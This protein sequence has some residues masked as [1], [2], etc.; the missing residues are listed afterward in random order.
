MPQGEDLR[1]TREAIRRMKRIV[2]LEGLICLA[3]EGVIASS[4][5]L[6]AAHPGAF[7][8]L[9]NALTALDQAVARRATE[10]FPTLAYEACRKA[11]R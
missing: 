3:E 10:R 2:E 1:V 4:R 8:L 5:D 11:K 9:E 7:P 6:V